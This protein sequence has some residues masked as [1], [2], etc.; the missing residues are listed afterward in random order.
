M[1]RPK[2]IILQDL[3]RE[4]EQLA[5]LTRAQADVVACIESL[6]RS[7]PDGI[8]HRSARLVGRVSWTPG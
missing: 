7:D 6:G 4:K 2:D 8:R 1:T 5:Q 3:A